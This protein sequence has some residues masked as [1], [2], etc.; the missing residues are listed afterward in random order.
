MNTGSA[1]KLTSALAMAAAAPALA[2]TCHSRPDA[3]C[4]RHEGAGCAVSSSQQ[5]FMLWWLPVGS[6]QVAAAQSDGREGLPGPLTLFSPLDGSKHGKGAFQ[7]AF[8]AL[9]VTGETCI[10]ANLDGAALHISASNAQVYIDEDVPV[11]PGWHGLS[12]AIFPRAK[13]EAGGLF[14]DWEVADEE[15]LV[16]VLVSFQVF[17]TSLKQVSTDMSCTRPATS[18][19]GLKLRVYETL[20]Y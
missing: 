19:C 4:V 12:L 15:A 8:S 20:S 13:G 1:N 11:E 18:V 5:E 7:L 10:M 16:E 9:H 2:R 3:A 6:I 17:A 14:C